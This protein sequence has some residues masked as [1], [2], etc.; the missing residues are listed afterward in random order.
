MD[1]S[2]SKC[3]GHKR[4]LRGVW[5]EDGDEVKVFCDSCQSYERAFA[6]NIKK[7][8]AEQAADM[9]YCCDNCSQ[10]RPIDAEELLRSQGLATCTIC[11]WVGYP[12]VVPKG[13]LDGKT[14]QQSGKGEK[15]KKRS[16]KSK[17]P[18]EKA[19]SLQDNVTVV[20]IVPQHSS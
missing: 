16:E 4:E 10:T 13:Q 12:E 19:K 6:R 7:K 1:V 18:S 5:T 14:K 11:G 20:S 15:I 17:R 2:C 8:A 3:W 9:E